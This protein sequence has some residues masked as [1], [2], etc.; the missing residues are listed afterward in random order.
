[1]T[2]IGS[3][4]Q[5]ARRH[6]WSLAWKHGGR[7]W[8]WEQAARDVR[9]VARAL[10]ALGV[11]KG[12]PVAIVGPNRPEWVMADLG[13]LAAAA[14]PAPIYPTLTGEQARY[15][16]NHSGAAVAL[17]ADEGQR[18]KLR[19]GGVPTFALFSAW[20]QFLARGEAISDSQVTERVPGA[21]GAVL[22]RFR[23]A[24]SHA[25]AQAQGGLAEIRA[26]DRRAVR[27]GLTLYNASHD[28]NCRMTS[29]KRSP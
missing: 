23:R 6:P 2:A 7:E 26:R 13:A 8:T 28:R 29:L 27:A 18:D 14:I 4:F 1:M 11:Q 5:S 22:H 24:H 3:F 25:Q 17:V 21:G 9:R 16:A 10:I 12:D 15:V 20:D 19:G